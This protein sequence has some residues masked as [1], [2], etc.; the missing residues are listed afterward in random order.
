MCRIVAP[1]VYTRKDLE[2][3]LQVY[4]H[5]NN[6]INFEQL[7][8]PDATSDADATACFMLLLG[9]CEIIFI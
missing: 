4:W 5:D 7:A 2:A 6:V 9:K 8:S 3:C 1:S